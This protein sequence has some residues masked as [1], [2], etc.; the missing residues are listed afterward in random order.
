MSENELAVERVGN[1]LKVSVANAETE[2]LDGG[3]W[4]AARLDSGRILMVSEQCGSKPLSAEGVAKCSS[5]VLHDMLLGLHHRR[6]S[7]AVSIDTGAGLKKLFFRNG[8]LTFASST[9][10]DDRLGEVI[11]RDA[12]ITLD[13]L[14]NSAVQVDRATKFGQV[15]LR[16]SI[17]SNTD[18]WNALKNQVFE[19]F[20]SIFIT[21]QVYLEISQASPPTEVSFEDDTAKLIESAYSSGRQFRAFFKRLQNTSKLSVLEGQRVNE[22]KHG[23]F[24]SDMISLVRK[25]ELVSDLLDISKLTDM[26][27]LWVLHKMSCLGYVSFSQLKDL[28]NEPVDAG[29]ATLRGKIDSF[30][31]LQDFA[32]KGFSAAGIEYP[33]SCLQTFAWSL[34]EGQLAAIY[35]ND[36]GFLGEECKYNVMNQCYGNERRAAFFEMRFDSLIRYSLQVVGDLLPAD[37][38]KNI[39]RQFVEIST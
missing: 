33:V 5:D 13:Q 18:L 31:M 15:L 23:T 26:N 34:N 16:D 21:S 6:W 17:F 2:G 4:I 19:I 36:S 12:M 7:G 25:H 29:F 8:N 35:I 30:S 1:T 9:L 14:T 38:A 22:L 11:Y 28:R 3:K 27:T 20:R 24:F 39:K 32:M 37:A 10:I